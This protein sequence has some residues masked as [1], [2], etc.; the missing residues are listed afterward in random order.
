MFLPKTLTPKILMNYTEKN[1]KLHQQF[2]LKIFVYSVLHFMCTY[3]YVWVCVCVCIYVYI[4]Q[5][6][7]TRFNSLNI[8]VKC[9][10]VPAVFLLKKPKPVLCNILST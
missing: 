10:I 7:G 2:H 5:E 1:G 6:I 3:T 4:G 9:R 8:C